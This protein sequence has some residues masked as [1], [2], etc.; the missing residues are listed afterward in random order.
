MGVKGEIVCGLCGARYV[1]WMKADAHRFNCPKR[2]HGVT[3]ILSSSMG[4]S[5]GTGDVTPTLTPQQ[6][7]ENQLVQD[8]SEQIRK[9]M[10]K[11]AKRLLDEGVI[12]S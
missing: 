10:R 2:S 8:F 4:W 6:I 11:E 5:S 9:A 7:Q 12:T 3:V 1:D